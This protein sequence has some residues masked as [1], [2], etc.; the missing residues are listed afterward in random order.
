MS[1]S[2]NVNFI[3]LIPKYDSS[4]S[5]DEYKPIYLCNC[6]YKIIVNIIA[7]RDKS[8]LSKFISNEKFSFLSRK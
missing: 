1:V 5:F 7:L 8:L 2:F 4:N 3:A 6:I